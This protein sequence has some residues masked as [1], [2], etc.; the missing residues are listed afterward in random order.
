MAPSTATPP[1][2]R[3]SSLPSAIFVIRFLLVAESG[4]VSDSSLPYFGCLHLPLDLTSLLWIYVL[5]S[6]IAVLGLYVHADI[7]SVV[8]VFLVLLLWKP[9]GFWTSWPTS[10]PSTLHPHF[11]R[12]RAFRGLTYSAFPVFLPVL[13]CVFSAPDLAG[14]F[15]WL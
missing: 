12:L 14:R 4:G 5:R 3:S 11:P 15:P 1:P 10:R 9:A 7:F 2:S 6:S 13:S 8:E